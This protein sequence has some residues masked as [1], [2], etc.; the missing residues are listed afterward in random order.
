MARIVVYEYVIRHP[1]TGNL[2]AYFHYA[3]EL[4]PGPIVLERPWTALGTNTRAR[5]SGAR[6]E[7]GFGTLTSDRVVRDRAKTSTTI[8]GQLLS[9]GL[10]GVKPGDL[11]DLGDG[12]IGLLVA[13][14]DRGYRC[15]ARHRYHPDQHKD[16]HAREAASAPAAVVRPGAVREQSAYRDLP[17]VP[18]AIMGRTAFRVTR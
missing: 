15:L 8:S 5:R 4:T 2:F 14:H 9:L 1:I 10:S 3:C 6:A 17:I 11:T 12:D 7:G 16:K 13:W 18:A